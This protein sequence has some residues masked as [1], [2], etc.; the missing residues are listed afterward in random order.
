MCRFPKTAFNHFIF[1]MEK[2]NNP[3]ENELIDWLEEAIKKEHINYYEYDQFNHIRKISTSAFSIVYRA[4]WKRTEKVF[5][6]K[7]LKCEKM[8]F[9]EIV[10]EVIISYGTI[11][12]LHKIDLFFRII[13]LIYNVKLIFMKTSY[14][15]LEF[16]LV[17]M[18]I[19]LNLIII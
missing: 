6:L 11:L 18:V 2:S 10:N 19:R 15:S 8:A 14:D 3:G 1:K 4:N 13:R 9:K 16:L 17:K 7:A 5:A 12:F